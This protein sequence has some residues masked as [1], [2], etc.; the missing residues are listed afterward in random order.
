MQQEN[1]GTVGGT[2]VDVADVQEAGVD[3][4]HRAEGGRDSGC[5]WGGLDGHATVPATAAEPTVA[6][7]SRITS[8]TAWG[9]EIMITCEPST[10]VIVAPARSAIERITSVPAALSPVATTAHDGRSF[11]AGGPDGSENAELGDGSLRGSDQCGLLVGEIAR[12]GVAG[13]RRVDG[14][15]RRRSA[16]RGRVP[17]GDERAV[18]DAVLRSRLGC[19]EG[20]ALLGG[21]GRHVDEADDVLRIGR[22]VRDH[23]A[24]VRVADGD[25]GPFDLLEDRCDV[26]GVGGDSTQ[27]VR[28]CRHRHALGL[29]PL[30]HAVPAR[31]VGERA[32]HEH[33]GRGIAV[34]FL[35]HECSFVQTPSRHDRD[36]VAVA[37][38]A[39]SISFTKRAA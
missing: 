27:R 14:E 15:L 35:G 23:R 17:P 29:Q 9:C 18:Q 5:L 37:S 4:L 25:H 19:A 6:T 34:R 33:D 8:V 36:Q 16:V 38:I 7:A 31:R 12:E 28:R 32:V 1:R 10:S 11:H 39:C 13:L 3:L 22:G 30:D 24:A 20:L 26:G 21:E 2:E